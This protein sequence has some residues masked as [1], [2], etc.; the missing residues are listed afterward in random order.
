MQ[1]RPVEIT[2]A[3]SIILEG[4]L[5]LPDS[6]G[7][8]VSQGVVICHPHSLYGGEM[9]NVVVMAI[10]AAVVQR[11]LAA[12]RFNFR[13]VGRS[14]GT[15]ADGIGEVDD[16]EAALAWLVTAAAMNSG[17]GGA[18]S[19]NRVALAGY[20][21]GGGVALA[22]SIR[23]PDLAALALISPAINDDAAD[24]F[25]DLTMPK[26][27]ATGEADNFATI[28]RVRSLAARLPGA[29]ELYIAPQADHFWWGEEIALGN[30]VAD[31]ITS[32]F[33]RAGG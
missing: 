12:L 4:Q 3:D 1:T 2:S 6:G 16:A 32:A 33:A 8:S 30:R 5:D 23:R 9:T 15:Y 22:A 29:T 18:M 13:G 21:F 20:S 28:E 7:A 26:L 10:A 27:I 11:G 24:S 19:G 14:T 31:F 17:S 25:G